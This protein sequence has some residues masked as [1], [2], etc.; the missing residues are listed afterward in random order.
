[1]N[2]LKACFHVSQLKY[3]LM[4][5]LLLLLDDVVA[6]LVLFTTP[7]SRS[8]SSTNTGKSGVKRG[9]PN[10]AGKCADEGMLREVQQQQP[11]NVWARKFQ[12]IK[13]Q[14]LTLSW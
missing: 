6:V 9:Q 3:R 13:H 5:L 14:T 12:K 1:M 10:V 11:N 4:L 8:L 7:N 2:I